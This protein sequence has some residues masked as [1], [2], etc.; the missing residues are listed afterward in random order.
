M[1]KAAG[2]AGMKENRK[3]GRQIGDQIYGGKRGRGRKRE[4]GKESERGKAKGK[5][6][7]E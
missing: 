5:R 7:R 2:L 4:A 3:G 1:S 6:I